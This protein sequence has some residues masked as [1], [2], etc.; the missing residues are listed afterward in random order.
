MQSLYDMNLTEHRDG[1]IV[2]HRIYDPRDNIKIGAIYPSNFS[3]YFRVIEYLGMRGNSQ[4]FYKIQFIETG[5]IK[6]V[7]RQCIYKGKVKD[8]NILEKAHIGKRY[9]TNCGNTC[10]IIRR[11]PD[12][13]YADLVEA[14]FDGTGFRKISRLPNFKNGKI[15][16]PYYPSESGIGYLGEG[17]EKMMKSDKALFDKLYDRWRNMLRRCYDET[18]S[19]YYKYGKVGVHVCDRWHNLSNYIFDIIQLPG[20]DRTKV[21]NGEISLDKDKLQ[22]NEPNKQ[23]S[24]ETCVWLTYTEQVPY[25]NRPMVFKAHPIIVISTQTGET[26]EFDTII[27]CAKSL[28]IS[29][30][31]IRG[32]AELGLEY[33]GYRFKYKE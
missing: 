4:R 2:I 22:M 33:L 18:S 20:F 30:G 19:G 5:T 3:G 13:K 25:T 1:K 12:E 31:T 14:I 7:S 6:E 27:D 28:N 16:D 23:Y 24:P 11:V 10:T 8:E 26:M 21:L 17:Y 29:E 9:K 32:K 15:K